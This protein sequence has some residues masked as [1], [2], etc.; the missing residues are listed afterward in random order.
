M[1]QLKKLFYYNIAF[2]ILLFAT[3]SYGQHSIDELKL[4]STTIIVKDLKTSASWYRKFLRFKVEE[5]KPNKHVKMRNDVFVII[6]NQGN[7]TLLRS[8][9]NFKGDKKYVNGIDKIGFDTNRFDSLHLYFSHYE[10][11]ITTDIKEEKNLGHRIFIVEDPDGNKVQFFD[12]PNDKKNLS[13]TPSFFSIQS[14]DYINTLKWYTEH[15]GFKE[16]A[17]PDDTNLH[18]QN[19]L[20]K[21]GITLELL[22]LPYKSLETTEFMPVERDLA[23]FDQ[24]VLKTGLA[25]V[26]AFE[27]DN[28]GNKIVLIK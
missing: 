3:E 23:Q 18:F 9:I 28:N 16:I 13:I 4:T 17:L 21:D 11:K 27:M 5:F 8:Q 25:K 2:I 14:S 1:I 6:L 22:H 20:R 15:M 7:S 26:K 10:Q 24:L 12:A 19:F